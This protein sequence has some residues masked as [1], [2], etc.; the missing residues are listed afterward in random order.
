MNVAGLH[1]SVASFRK[2]FTLALVM[3]A[4]S[5]FVHPGLSAAVARRSA[6]GFY[7]LAAGLMLLLAL[8]PAPTAWGIHF[9]TTAP[10]SWLMSLPIFDVS[11]RAPGRFGMLMALALSVAAGLAWRY[12]RPAFDRWSARSIV[13]VAG[14]VLAEGWFAPVVTHKVPSHLIWPDRCS[15][16]P[17][18]E[19]PLGDTDRDAAAQY[20]AFLDGTRSV[21]GATGFVPAYA[22]ALEGALATRDPETLP[23][24]AEHG[25]ICLLVDRA[26]DG[27]SD[28]AGWLAAQP[29]VESIEST[30]E[31]SVYYLRRAPVA[32]PPPVSAPRLRIAGATSTSG[33]VN[34]RAL[35]DHDPISAWMTAGPQRSGNMLGVT[36]QCDA[37][38][39]DVVV[40]QGATYAEHFA[41]A[42]AIEVSD[43][44]HDWRS[45][46]RG[47]TG[48]RI[49]RAA[50]DD[51]R[52]VTIRFRLD[53]K[54]A[55]HLRFRLRAS[56][57]DRWWVVAGLEVHGYC[58]G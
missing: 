18:L 38:L 55:R 30:A 23:A 1:A 40:T 15:A 28:L 42:L 46:W 11:L 29:L 31:R 49:V 9:L 27:A 48:A 36:L 56:D 21:N 25:P 45:E 41:R 35:T 24:L 33:P 7:V 12:L 16:L 8:G 19:L 13:A 52:L 44:G 5:V 10:Y 22:R 32:P 34:I 20:R 37:Q 26:R 6:F 53:V 39:T 54:S 2:P 17:R 50:I 47:N 58:H 43:E 4:A 57:P 3:F 14:L 51:P